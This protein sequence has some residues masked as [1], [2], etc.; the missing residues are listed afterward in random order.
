MPRN[1]LT[2]IYVAGSVAVTPNNI[3]AMTRVNA[4]AVKPGVFASVRAGETEIAQ[5]SIH[6]PY[7]AAQ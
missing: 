6:V 7:T 3:P 1:T 4:I 5:Q 2:A